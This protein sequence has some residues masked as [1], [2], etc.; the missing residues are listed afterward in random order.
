MTL[1]QTCLLPTR[2]NDF[3][4]LLGAFELVASSRRQLGEG[5]RA[6]IRQCMTLEPSS[7]IFE[8]IRR[9]KT[10]FLKSHPY[11]TGPSPR[12]IDRGSGPGGEK[13]AR[14]RRILANPSLQA[15]RCLGARGRSPPR[16]LFFL[17]C[18]KQRCLRSADVQLPATVI[19]S[20]RIEPVRMLPRMSTS[21]PTATRPRNMSFRL[22]ATVI[23]STG[24]WMT[25]F[26]TQKPAAPRE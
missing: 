7:Q 2:R 6:A 23:S 21:L 25:P 13:K 18:V 11:G 24:Y 14:H 16:V 15:D 3:W 1:K 17:R 10:S 20:I 9:I 26:S 4:M 22:P 8:G 19:D 5:F 12:I